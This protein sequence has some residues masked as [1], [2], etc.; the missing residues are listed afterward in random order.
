[1]ANDEAGRPRSF[2]SAV[3]PPLVATLVAGLLGPLHSQ[4]PFE[5]GL[6]AWQAVVLWPIGLFLVGV[7]TLLLLNVRSARLLRLGQVAI[8]V[9]GVASTVA[10]AHTDDAQAGLWFLYPPVLGSLLVLVLL[11]VDGRSG[12]RGR[13]ERGD[14]GT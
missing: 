6:L 7:P 12:R 5:I 13:V 8:G 10:V 14:V 11:A 2:G 9:L 1:M 4:E 3:L